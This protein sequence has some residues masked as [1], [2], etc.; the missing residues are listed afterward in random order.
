[1]NMKHGIDALHGT[2]PDGEQAHM[3]NMCMLKEVSDVYFTTTF[4]TAEVKSVAY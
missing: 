4:A 2:Q 3:T 1:M